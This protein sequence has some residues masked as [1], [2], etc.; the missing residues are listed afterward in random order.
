[1]E[2]YEQA[3]FSHLMLALE[4]AQAGQGVALASPYLVK[5]DLENG[6]LVHVL[7]PAVSSGY[8]FAVVAR[9][10]AV[11]VPHIRAFIDWTVMESTK[12]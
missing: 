7:G 4:A 12:L 9:P 11:A 10:E 1:M 5:S 2:D 8:D 6:R 3:Q